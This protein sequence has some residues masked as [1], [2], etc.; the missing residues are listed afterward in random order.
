LV[1]GSVIAMDELNAQEFP[2]ETIAF[3]EVFPL[4]KYPI[5]RSKF[6]PDRSY[7]VIT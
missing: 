4:A 1:K 3:K 5:Y 2:G 7:M 6:L